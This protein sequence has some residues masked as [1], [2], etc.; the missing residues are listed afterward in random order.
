MK[1]ILQIFLIGLVLSC[2]IK[3]NNE[4]KKREIIKS[5]IES[6]YSAKKNGEIDRES[7]LKENIVR[8]EFRNIKNELIESWE[9]DPENNGFSKTILTRDSIGNLLKGRTENFN[10]K[11]ISYYI[12]KIDSNGNIIEY[13]TYGSEGKL[14]SIQSSKFDL[15][16]NETELKLVDLMTLNTFITEFKYNDKNQMIEKKQIDQRRE[17]TK[18]RRYKYDTKGNSIEELYIKP[19]KSETLFKNN[20]DDK[21][22]LIKNIWFNDGEQTHETSFEYV[23][24][25]YENWI[26]KKRSSNG[27]LNYIWEREIEYYN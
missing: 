17:K 23:Y 21:N 8:K 5:I 7:A 3:K 4:P 24:D 25:K 19:D 20:Y 16:G 27:E 14:Y 13:K 11:L 26:T 18:I 9:F 2:S 15:F 1:K 22:N 12:T 10:G 6:Q